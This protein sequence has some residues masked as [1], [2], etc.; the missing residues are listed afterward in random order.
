MFHILHSVTKSFASTLIG[1][2]L[3]Q[4]LLDNLSQR[5]I[6]FF[7]EYEIQNLDNRKQNMTIEHLLTMTTGLDWDEQSYPYTDTERNNH[8]ALL[9]SRDSMEYFLNVPMAYE[10]GEQWEY[11]GGASIALCAIV[12]QISGNDTQ[13]FAQEYLFDPLGISSL[14]WLDAPG[15][16]C[17]GGGGLFLAP[18]DMAKLGLLYMNNGV[19]DGLQILPEDW[20]EISTENLWMRWGTPEQGVGYGRHWWTMPHLDV[21]FAFGAYGQHIFVDASN[22][23]IVTMTG[24]IGNDEYYPMFELFED[25]IILAINGTDNSLVIIGVGMT[26]T[27]L[28][29]VIVVIA[30]KRRGRLGIE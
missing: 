14:I 17:N 28:V 10:P 9:S 16:W 24:D 26:I 15:G 27:G 23:L 12:E 22:S 13:D 29:S 4:G 21:Y 7:P 1:I 6:D 8:G 19:W 2:A 5:V 18:K 11:C 30:F 3:Y 25:Y 20:V